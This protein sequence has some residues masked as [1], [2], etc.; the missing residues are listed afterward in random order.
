M[1]LVKQEFFAALTASGI[2]EIPGDFSVAPVAQ[3]IPLAT[4]LEIDHFIRLFDRVNNPHYLATGRHRIG[5]G[6]RAISAQ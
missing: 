1:T 6:D 3:L 2:P 5:A 4:L